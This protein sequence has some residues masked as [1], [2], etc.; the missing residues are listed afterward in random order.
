MDIN[1]PSKL[2]TNNTYLNP[3]HDSSVKHVYDMFDNTGNEEYK[4]ISIEPVD[5][6]LDAE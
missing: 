2:E 6:M 5:T 3:I 4:Y 1:L